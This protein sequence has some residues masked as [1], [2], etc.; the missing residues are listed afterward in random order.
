MQILVQK[1][2]DDNMIDT[3]TFKQG[4]S[5]Y[6]STLETSTKTADEFVEYFSNILLALILIHL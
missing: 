4:V 3:V 1:I 2:L 5:V 6:R